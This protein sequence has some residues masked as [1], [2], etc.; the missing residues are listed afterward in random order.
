MFA[1][2]H[3]RSG[4]IGCGACAAFCPEL[5]QM[6]ADGKSILMGAKKSGT[7]EE[8]LVSEIGANKDAAEGCP[9]NVIHIINKDTGEKII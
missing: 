1:I 2:Q 9:V 6:D 5:W 7:F 8:L 3:E 4:C